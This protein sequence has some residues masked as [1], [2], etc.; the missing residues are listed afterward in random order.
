MNKEIWKP[1]VCYEG[2]YLVSNFGRVYSIKKGI[3]L[4]ATDNGRGY[5]QV[6]LWK[7]GK[8]YTHRIHRLVADAFIPNPYNLPEVNHIDENK[9]NN[10]VENL[11]WC[12]HEYNTAYGDRSRKVREKTTNGKLSAPVEQIKPNG[13]RIIYPS[14]QEAHRQ[15]GISQGNIS[16]VCNGKRKMAGGSRWILVN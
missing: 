14:M 3:L 13:Q 7:N 6:G 5:L 2:L 16:E 1:V 15:T 9:L 10:C 4:K 8:H 12:T 11:E